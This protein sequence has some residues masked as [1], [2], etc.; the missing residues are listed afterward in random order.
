MPANPSRLRPERSRIRGQSLLEFALVVPI[1]LLIFAGAAD[2]GRIFYTYVAIENAA[3]EGALYGARYPLC[4]TASTLCPNPGNADFRARQETLN[5]LASA[6]LN[7]T[8]ECFPRAGGAAYGPGNFELCLPGDR[9]TVTADTDFHLITP[10][11]SD[12]MGGDFTLSNTATS[13]VLNLAFDPTPG[14]GPTKLVLATNS[15][16]PA[17]IAAECDE[18]DPIGSPGYYRSPCL[19][20]A[21]GL[22]YPIK[23]RSG[24]QIFYKIFARNNGGTNLTGVTMNDSLGW[25][26]GCPTRPT[27]MAVGGA[28]YVCS[29]SRIA[30]TIPGAAVIMDY[31]NT[32][33]VDGNEILATT[34]GAT[35][36]VEKP[37]ADLQALKFVSPYF[38]GNDGDG[39][40]TWGTNDTITLNRSASVSN[41]QVWFRLIVTNVG[42]QTASGLAVVDSDLT[43]PVN[44]ACP[45][46][47]ATLAVGASWICRYQQTYSANE[48]DP[49]TITATATNA[50][51]DAGDVHTATVTVQSCSAGNRVVPMVIGQNKAAAQASWLAAG[52]TPANLSVWSG[53]AASLTVTQS[54]TAYTCVAPTSTMTITR[55][56]T[57]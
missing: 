26:G 53:G 6:D 45:A 15:R 28:A 42:G 8:V 14:V 17:Q 21:T 24:D 55:T 1:L 36:T 3:K 47:P 32:Y 46:V 12:L 41:V 50:T 18:P 25:P 16:N 48:V 38:D 31:I 9:Y 22:Q 29:Y 40:A 19:N 5:V 11:L 54:Q 51:P 33:T 7:I 4:D 44:A 10:L 39:V 43:L 52:F 2:L 20:E 57:P 27:T 35:V 23:F 34:D 30:P 56:T 37:P 13:D 49:N